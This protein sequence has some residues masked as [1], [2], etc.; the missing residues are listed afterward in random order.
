MKGRYFGLIEW[1]FL[2][3]LTFKSESVSETVRLPMFFA[4]QRRCERVVGKKDLQLPWVLRLNLGGFANSALSLRTCFAFK[5]SWGCACRNGGQ[6]LRG[7]W[8]RC[9]HRN[10]G[11][12]IVRV[13]LFDP[14]L[15]AEWYLS[16]ADQYAADLLGKRQYESAKFGARSSELMISRSACEVA[17]SRK[18]LR[19]EFS[20][21]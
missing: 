12:G 20:A 9:D 5:N 10:Q 17:A 7:V 8:Q 21:V 15:G 2:C 1:H 3:T 14:T 4:W 13:D 11:G 19:G 18:G 16:K 6:Q